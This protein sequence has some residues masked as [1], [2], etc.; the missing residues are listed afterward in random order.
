M[1]KWAKNVQSLGARFARKGDEVVNSVQ[2]INAET[3]MKIFI[4]ENRSYT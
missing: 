1:E 2:M 3:D 4:D